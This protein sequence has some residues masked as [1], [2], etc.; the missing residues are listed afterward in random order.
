MSA[1]V[2]HVVFADTSMGP[3]V[4]PGAL[5]AVLGRPLSLAEH[6]EVELALRVPGYMD[7]ECG[8]AAP[9][10]T[11]VGTLRSGAKGDNVHPFRWARITH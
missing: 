5:G 3:L 8:R 2:V 10:E 4:L 6:V 1:T 9:T 7:V 11:G